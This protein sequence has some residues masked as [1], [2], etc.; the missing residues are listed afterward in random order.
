MNRW[1]TIAVTAL[2]AAGAAATAAEKETAI[3]WP[4]RAATVKVG[5]TPAEVEK[6][7]PR[8]VAPQD[9]QKRDILGI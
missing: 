8:W 6:I 4:A 5:M 3:D 7:L 2:L 1:T 9:L